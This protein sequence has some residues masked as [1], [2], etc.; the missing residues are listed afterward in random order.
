MDFFRLRAS[1]VKRGAIEISM[2]INH[3]GADGLVDKIWVLMQAGIPR[4]KSAAAL[5][6]KSWGGQGEKYV[7]TGELL[8]APKDDWTCP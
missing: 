7:V 3:S 8:L 5:S 4:T 6:F 1:G 2:N